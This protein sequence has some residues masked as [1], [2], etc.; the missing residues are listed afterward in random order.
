[1][2]KKTAFILI[3]L[4]LVLS[5][6]FAAGTFGLSVK[7]SP[8]SYQY[9]KRNAGYAS[10]YGFAAELGY[11]HYVWKGH[12]VGVDL[13]Y[14][15]FS[16]ADITEKYH[17]ISASIKAGWT[18][19]F[20][21]KWSMDG[22]LGL[23]IQGRKVDT[24]KDLFLALSVYVGGGYQVSQKTRITAGVVFEPTFQEDSKDYTVGA[25]LGTYIGF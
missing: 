20:G 18:Q 13:K 3:L 12:S 15:N 7:A 25:M 11:R 22:E 17:V 2:L 6:T 1:M 4:V 10:T 23:G 9:V 24:A 8:Y 14:E 16:Y 5:C 19:R 21:E